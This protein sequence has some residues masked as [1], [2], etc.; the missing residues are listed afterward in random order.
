MHYFKAKWPWLL[1]LTLLLALGA[2]AG[3][4]RW[5]AANTSVKPLPV[6]HEADTRERDIPGVGQSGSNEGA[7]LQSLEDYWNARVTYPTGRFNGAWL[8]NAANQDK[9]VQERVPAGQVIYRRSGNSPLSLDPSSWT[10]LGPQP[11]QSN[12][13][14]GCYSVWSCLGTRQLHHG[15]PGG[16][17]CGLPGA[18][19]GGVWKTTNCC[20]AAT[21]WV[22]SPTAR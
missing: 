8:L 16:P 17:H 15:R 6:S 13:C 14:I 7:E 1:G 22:P 12:G 3:I 4:L 5:Q 11:L 2:G 19:G 20:S 18:V 10:S 21:T 9:Q